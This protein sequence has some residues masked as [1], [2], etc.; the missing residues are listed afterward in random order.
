[1]SASKSASNGG[2]G[3]EVY[4][5]LRLATAVSGS[6]SSGCLDLRVNG[7]A[8]VGVIREVA[9]AGG[10]GRHTWWVHSNVRWRQRGG[11]DRIAQSGGH[12]PAEI[13]IR[14]QRGKTRL[15]LRLGRADK[16]PNLLIG[17]D[18]KRPDPWLGLRR[19]VGEGQYR[20]P[21]TPSDRCDCCRFRGGQWADD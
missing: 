2:G 6:K 11:F 15:S 19:V 13:G 18:S 10:D 12:R 20:N 7:S 5:L 1:M 8:A 9:G 4:K 17:R 21:R 3:I 14:Q 16:A